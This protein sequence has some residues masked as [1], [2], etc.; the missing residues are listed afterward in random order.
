M[1]I[2]AS[3]ASETQ[4]DYDTIR[5]KMA[6]QMED[7]MAS[8]RQGQAATVQEWWTTS[9]GREYRI[10]TEA[11]QNEGQDHEKIL[12]QTVVLQD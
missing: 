8:V 5:G 3:I 12:V 7:V 6:T 4:G 11:P 2:V 1:S 10:R 9:A